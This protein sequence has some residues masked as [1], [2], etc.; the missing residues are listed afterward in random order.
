MAVQGLKLGLFHF[1]SQA[2]Q[3]E[4]WLLNFK[5]LLYAYGAVLSI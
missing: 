3:I 2:S 4:I 5:L 1:Y